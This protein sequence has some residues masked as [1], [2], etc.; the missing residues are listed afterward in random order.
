MLSPARR[1]A[2]NARPAAAQLESTLSCIGFHSSTRA[3]ASKATV[4]LSQERSGHARKGS[5]WLACEQGR[6]ERANPT[7]GEM[8]K[9]WIG[10]GQRGGARQK[11][12]KPPKCSSWTIAVPGESV[13][14]RQRTPSDAPRLTAAYRAAN[15][16]AHSGAGVGVGE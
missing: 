12:S 3:A 13:G 2:S 15:H 5:R 1:E 8:R 10:E 6:C 4:G 7:R 14:H 9:G 16:S 11:S